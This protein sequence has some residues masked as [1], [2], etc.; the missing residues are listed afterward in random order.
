MFVL[1]GYAWFRGLDSPKFDEELSTCEYPGVIKHC[2]HLEMGGYDGR[3]LYY[4]VVIAG[5]KKVKVDASKIG[6]FTNG[7]QIQGG[8]DN[9]ISSYKN[10]VD[11][12][13]LF[14]LPRSQGY[15]WCRRELNFEE[16][17]ELLLTSCRACR[18]DGG[19]EKTSWWLL[20]IRA[21]FT[22]QP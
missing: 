17:N 5:C 12:V 19:G 13:G 14:E 7:E 22:V 15:G 2:T 20:D 8:S 1:G 6:E 21:P 9:V 18:N 4:I 3:L 11:D 16:A 10:W